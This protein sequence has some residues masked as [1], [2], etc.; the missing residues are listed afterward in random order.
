MPHKIVVLGAGIIGITSAIKL[1]ENGFA[2]TVLS[3]DEPFQTN[4]DS[5]VATWYAPDDV[6]PCL[7]VLCLESLV[8]FDALSKEPTSGV[9]RISM[10]Y[11]FKDEH[12]F[13]Q[14]VWSNASWKNLLNISDQLPEDFIKH[15]MFTKA[16][17]AK[18]PLIDINIYRPFLL[19]KFMQLGGQ[20]II[21]KIHAWQDLGDDWTMI[22]NCAG[23][24]AAFLTQDNEVYP[25]RGQIEVGRAVTELKQSYSFNVTDLNAYGVF[26]PQSNEWVFGTT[27]QIHD[28]EKQ[29]RTVDKDA[30]LKKVAPFF[31]EI[32][33]LK[34]TSRVG[35]RC[36]RPDVRIEKEMLAGKQGNPILLIHCYGHGG[37]G[38]SASWGS[39]EQV[40]K[41][42]FAHIEKSNSSS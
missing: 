42:C 40:L 28:T 14:S 23:W 6:K 22:I 5:A 11:Y 12:A 25:V 41:Y 3:K 29:A 8:Y 27:Y 21:K 17:A 33:L 39:A 9:Q 31:P 38:V 37:S 32:N 26:K 2:V 10:V 13:Q 20:F 34:T 19:K 35:I 24:E 1:L 30:I 36:G 18:I 4:S 16:V 15:D 7:Q